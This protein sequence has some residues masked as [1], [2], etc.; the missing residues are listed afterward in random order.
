MSDF[1][2]LVNDGLKNLV[3][4]PRTSEEPFL[5][6]EFKAEFMAL[7][8]IPA[9]PKPYGGDV[10]VRYCPK[11]LLV[12]WDSVQKFFADHKSMFLCAE[13]VAALVVEIMKA[14]TECTNLQ[15]D[16]AVTSAF[17][18]PVHI[19]ASWDEQL[20]GIKELGKRLESYGRPSS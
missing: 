7:C 13:D 19:V 4:F 8:P 15:V 1:R 18:L 9:S 16:V 5:T 10:I 20:E 3:T 17:H 6:V 12:D 2:T 11:N 14:T